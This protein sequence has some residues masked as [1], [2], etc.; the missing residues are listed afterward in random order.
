[1]AMRTCSKCGEEKPLTLEYFHRDKSNIRC[2]L[3]AYCCKVCRNKQTQKYRE[4]N[5]EKIRANNKKWYEE[6]REKSLARMKKWRKENPEKIRARKKKWYEDNREKVSARMKKWRAENPHYTRNRNRNN[7][8]FRLHSNLR[9]GLWNCLSGKQK[10][11]HTLE[12]VG[13]D[14]EQLWKH[15]ESKFTDGMT[16]ENHGEWHVDHIRPLSSFDFDQFK[17][18]SKEYENMLHE[19]WNY[20]NLQP[21]WAKDNL[22]KH[23]KWEGALCQQL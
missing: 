10:K 14:L 3:I 15:F 21:L 1:M 18:G 7:P 17:E 12:Y 4:E 8:T 5:P 9:T 16:R 20:T 11:S 6:N 23:G 19:A 13:I 2:G 22:S